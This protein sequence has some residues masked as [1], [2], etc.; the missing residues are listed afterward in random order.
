MKIIFWDWNGTLVDDA[1]IQCQSFNQ[2]VQSRGVNPVTLERYRELYRHPISK[3]YEEVGID[4]GQHCFESIAQEWHDRYEILSHS[5]R[6]H[7]DVFE[8][9]AA[10]QRGVK[11]QMI[12]SALPHELL[13]AQV[14]RFGLA[15]FFEQV[16][17]MPDKLANSKVEQGRILASELG[18][19]GK[20][21][22]VIGDSS[23]DA[24]VAR[25]LNAECILIARGTESLQRLKRHGYRVFEDFS[26]LS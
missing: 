3:M 13:V 14:R 4:L 18:A 24:E 23:H 15:H 6:L 26:L 17:G 1:S 7:H 2:V 19:K 12:L 8:T 9:L 11:R 25:E 22:M 10:L 5:L 20:D 16:R 21:I